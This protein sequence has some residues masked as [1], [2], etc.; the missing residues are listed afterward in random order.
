MSEPVG[1]SE[2]RTPTP[3]ERAQDRAVVAKTMSQMTGKK[4][5]V[6]TTSTG[7]IFMP[8]PD[9]ITEQNPTPN[10]PLAKRDIK[11]AKEEKDKRH[12]ANL[13]AHTDRL[14]HRLPEK[15]HSKK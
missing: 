7:T 3:A 8:S 14:G 13:A 1:L 12:L 15:H 2:F 9:E 6:K 10:Q 11:N 4:I 5:I